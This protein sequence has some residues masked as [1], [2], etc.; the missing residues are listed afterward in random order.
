M[1]SLHLVRLSNLR[2]SAEPELRTGKDS[3]LKTMRAV[4]RK[5]I[6]ALAFCPMLVLSLCVGQ[7]GRCY[8]Q[9]QTQP[10]APPKVAVLRGSSSDD[11]GAPKTTAQPAAKPDPDIALDIA[12]ELAVMKARI[13][14]LEAELKSRTATTAP[15]P[16]SPQQAAAA[17]VATAKASEAAPSPATAVPPTQETRTGSPEKPAPTEPFAYADWTWLN[18]NARNKDVVWDSKFFTPEIR[19]DTDFVSSFNHPKDDSIG[20]STEIFRSNEVQLDQI[21]FGGDFH[22]QDVRGR[23]LTMGGMFGVT[24]PRNDGSPGRGQWDLRGAYKYFSEAYGGYHFNVNHGLNV[25]AGI[26]VSYIGLFSYYNFDNWAYQ[27]SYVSSNTPWFFNGLRIQWFPTDKLKIEPWIINGWQSYGRY[28]TKPGLGGQIL[29]RPKQWVSLVFNTYGMGE[30][31]LWTGNVPLGRSRFHSDNSVEIKYYDQPTK[32]LDKMAFSLTG[33]LGCEYGGGV[34]CHH[35]EPLVTAANG[36]PKGGPK[37]SFAG[38]MLYNRWWFDKDKYAITVGGGAFDNPGRYL[39]LLQPIN[40]ADAISGT[41]YFPEGPGLPFKAWDNSVTFDYMP[42]QYITFLWEFGYRHADVPYFT[43]R[44]GITPPGGNNGSPGQFVCMDNTPAGT[45]LT[46]TS[47]S[48]DG[49]VWYPDLRKD[50]PSLRMAIM[51]KF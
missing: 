19:L 16:E 8:A 50:E 42:K 41:P 40:G 2:L 18:G 36:S 3:N 24:T 23:V 29:Y 51:V 10:D 26:F 11:T 45:S 7:G 25:D 15:A 47:C 13:E 28:G 44:G 49:G 34:S 14:Q 31:T 46:P 33:D 39:T 22:W 21:S 35:N 43:G 38:W 32:F 37:Q 48:A 6:A 30:D 5:P 12:K 9:A 20:G 4:L 1:Q 17:P 27:P